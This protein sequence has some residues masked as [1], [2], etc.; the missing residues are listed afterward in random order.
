MTPD[1]DVDV[2]VIGAG[3][4][5]SAVAYALR[6]AG[7]RVLILERGGYLKQEHENWDPTEV[8]SNRRYESEEEWVDQYGK[9][10]CPRVYYNVGGS[11]KFFGGVALRFRRDDFNAR[12]Y[13]DGDTVAWPITYEDLAPFYDEAERLMWVHGQIGHDSTEPPR[14]EFPGPPLQHEPQIEWLS[15]RLA[16]VGLH[17]LPLP[18]AVDQ[19]TT[20]RC[21]K[22]SPCDGF[23]CKIRAKGDGENSFLRP[24]LR[25]RGNGSLEIRTNSR[26]VRFNHDERGRTVTSVEY[27]GGDERHTIAAGTFVLAAGAVNSAAI[28]LQSISTRFPSGLANSSDL[29]GRNFMA[30]NNTVLMAFSPFRRNPTRFQKTLALNDFYLPR[31]GDAGGVGPTQCPVGHIQMRGKVVE[32]NLRQ[33]PRFLVRTFARFIAA[34]SFDFWVM[35]EDLP[36]PDNRV[37]VFNGREIR[38]SRTLNNLGSHRALVKELKRILRRIGLPLV[39]ER[40]P[41]PQTIQHQC[42]TLRFGVDRRTSVLDPWCCS[43][44]L[45][46]LYVT[47]GS[48]FPS[49]AAVNPALTIAAN[50]LRVGEHI[51]QELC[52]HPGNQNP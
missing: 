38:L 30:H 2:V 27:L 14:G 20:G 51:R 34:H 43:H 52:E 10:F 24:A 46:N 16:G 12:S 23:P 35:S 33:S 25:A 18:M 45:T 29:V 47:D 5:G 41:S 17:P 50:A 28:L 6:E 8:I 11:S 9:R 4:G 31:V 21:R 44:D 42:G 13:P 32:Q 3:L 49:S 19:G 7:L 48:V 1:H 36:S 37:E 22:G 26:V 15:R 39:I 40:E